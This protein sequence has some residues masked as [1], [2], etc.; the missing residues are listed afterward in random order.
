MT[1]G[2]TRRL[3]HGLG[4]KTL[5]CARFVLPPTNGHKTGAFKQRK[6]VSFEIGL[7]SD[8]HPRSQVLGNGRKRAISSTRDRTGIFTKS[9]RRE[10]SRINAWCLVEISRDQKAS[11]KIAE[12]S[13]GHTCRETAQRSTKDL[14]VWLYPRPC[15]VLSWRVASKTKKG[16]W[17]PWSISQPRVASPVTLVGFFSLKCFGHLS[18]CCIKTSHKCF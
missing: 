10:T 6:A 17:K 8:P 4:K 9:S 11:Q 5:Y 3:I 18:H 1:E 12:A 13:P 7:C 16:C 15:W 14:V 2:R